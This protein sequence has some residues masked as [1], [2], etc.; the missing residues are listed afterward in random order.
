MDRWARDFDNWGVCDTLCFCLFDRTPHAWRKVSSWSRRRDELRE[1]GRLRPPGEPRPPR[2]A[3]R[4]PPVPR[5]LAAHRAGSTDE[6][7]FVKKGVSGHSDPWAAGALHSTPLR[8][9][10]PAAW[11]A[12]T[13]PRPGGSGGYAPR[14][15]QPKAPHPDRAQGRAPPGRIDHP[16]RRP[17]PASSPSRLPPLRPSAFTP[18]PPLR[19]FRLF[20]PSVLPPF[21]L[22]PSSAR[23]GGHGR[24]EDRRRSPVARNA[25][26]AR[27][28]RAGIA[29]DA[30]G[31]GSPP[32]AVARLA[33][34]IESDGG[35]VLATYRDPLGG[36]WQIFA[37]LPIDL[38]RAH[39]LPARPLRTRTSPSSARRSPARPLP[40]PD[41]RGAR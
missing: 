17:P 19:P 10:W 24:D 37:G 15:D 31:S 22:Q 34:A 28:A 27:P 4:R 41:D 40:R 6:R 30:L 29:P 39:A 21:P 20:R 26:R 25:P 11:P 7:N 8:S 1:A 2:Q 12:R 5:D 18:P 35:S 3:D 33:D 9:P 23:P 13:T 32:A 16:F 38:S 14:S 36:N